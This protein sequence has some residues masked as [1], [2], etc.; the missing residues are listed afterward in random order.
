[1]MQVVDGKG[2]LQ[3]LVGHGEGIAD[4]QAAGTHLLTGFVPQR[5][6]G[7]GRFRATR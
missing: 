7:H 2:F 6:H 1:M 3:R 4:E 5:L